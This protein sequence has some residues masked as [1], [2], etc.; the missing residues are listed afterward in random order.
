MWEGIHLSITSIPKVK[1]NCVVMKGVN[2]DEILDFVELAREKRIGV[3]FIE[4]MPFTGNS[5]ED[6]RFLPKERMIDLTSKKYSI[7]RITPE[8]PIA[9][10][11]E[12]SGFEGYI[13]FIA[14]MTTPFR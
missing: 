4:F 7:N 14:S 3:R 11:Y 12:I 13:G 9:E 8:D 1:L 2:E 6:S 10:Y 5:W